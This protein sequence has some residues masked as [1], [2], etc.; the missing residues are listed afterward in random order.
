M[1]LLIMTMV[2]PEQFTYKTKPVTY[3]EALVELYNWK[4]RGQIHEIHKMIQ[5]EKMHA[6]TA[7]NSDN[8]GTYWIIEI[9]SLF[10][11]THVIPRNQDKFVFYVNN[12][13][14]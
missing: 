12:Y 14:D 3:I 1:L 10:H 2:D 13:I 7:E 11:N 6:L 8:L 5:F 9:S 4:N